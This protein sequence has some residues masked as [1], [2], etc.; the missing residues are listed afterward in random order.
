M[1]NVQLLPT[2][3]LRHNSYLLTSVMM[4]RETIYTCL[5]KIRYEAKTNEENF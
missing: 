1:N 5:P 4:P 2:V 3:N